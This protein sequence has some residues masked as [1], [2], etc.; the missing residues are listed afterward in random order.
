MEK[1]KKQI[2]KKWWFWLIIILL[3]FIIGS[4]A[5]TNNTSTNNVTTNTSINETNTSISEE[6]PAKEN[7]N[8]T[9]T[10][11][12]TDM[13]LMSYAQLVLDDN[14]NKP[15]YSRSTSDYKFVQT[16]LRYKIEGNVEVN[17]TSNKFYMIIEFT[18]ETYKNYDLISLQV[19]NE[20]IYK[21]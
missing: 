12:P 19:G 7:E 14:L 4:G 17:S 1:E 20:T 18:D 13:E 10:N 3:I 21:K 11:T 8:N 16:N 2:Y 6:T 9:N 5:N 15:K